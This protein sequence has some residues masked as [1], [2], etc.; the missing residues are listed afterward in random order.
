MTET[1]NWYSEKQAT[2]GDRLAAAREAA[3]LSQSA[4]A[5]RLGVRQK[6][7]RAWESDLS[8]PRAN[9]L[10]MLAA[11]LGVSLRWLLTGEGE[12]ISP[13]AAPDEPGDSAFVQALSDLQSLRTE[14]VKVSERIGYLER[15]LRQQV[16]PVSG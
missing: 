2:L 7:L 5:T 9:R 11:M 16:G 12:G 8:E 15:K 14:L 13:P 10:Q 1:E 4:L 3:G 6:T